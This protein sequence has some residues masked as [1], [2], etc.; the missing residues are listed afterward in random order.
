MRK[1]LNG[2]GVP[3]SVAVFL[4]KD[5]YDHDDESISATSLLKPVRQIVLNSRLPPEHKLVDII[6]LTKSR[7]G[8]AI[9]D[10][11]EKAWKDNPKQTLM[12]LGYPQKVAESVIINPE[13]GEDITDRIPV[14]LEIRS[15]K[16]IMGFK[17]S[18]KFDFVAEGRVEDFKS[19]S[20]YTAM[21]G[22]KDDDYKLQ[23]SIYRWLNPEI[24]TQDEM[25]I[26]FFFTDW[27]RNQAKSNP[28][29]PQKPVDQKIIPLLSIEETE[30]YVRNK[31][32]QVIT[33]SKTPEENLPLCEDKDLWR[34]EPEYKYYKNPQKMNRSTKN[35]DNKLDAYKRLTDDG[36]VGIVVEVPG[37]VNACKYC[38]AFP[39]CTQKD[40]LIAEGSLVI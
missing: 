32:Q 25:A 39:L 11:I 13:P 34:T 40:A 5:Y 6:D 30:S 9:H 8:T 22:N 4:A 1:Y 19:T 16:E 33:H 29:Y 38:S 36:N 2:S 27:A 21:A 17:V 15:Y 3:L 18:G 20:V 28:K 12:E 10:G 14:Y 26:Q 24:I 35:F 23:G 37:Q 31:L 7:M